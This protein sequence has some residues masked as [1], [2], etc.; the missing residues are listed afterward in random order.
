MKELNGRDVGFDC[1]RASRVRIALVLSAVPFG[2][3]TS[4]LTTTGVPVLP[5]V[6]DTSFDVG[7][8][9][10]VQPRSTDGENRNVSSLFVKM[11]TV[12]A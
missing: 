2:T 12:N 11:V 5:S 3:V 10:A 1:E 6:F 7:F 9:T 8:A 4:T